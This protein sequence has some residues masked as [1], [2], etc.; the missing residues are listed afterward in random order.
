MKVIKQSVELMDMTEY[1]LH[2][3]ER[4]GRVCYKSEDQITVNSSEEF[5]RMLIK[6][7]HEAMIEHAH[8]SY[9]FVTDRGVTH[10]I[11][12]HR[13]FSY[14]QECVVGSTK[15]HQNYT[16]EDLYNRQ[17]SGN[18][19][20]K[21]H[22]KTI[23]LRSVNEDNEL[24]PN[25]INRILKK[26]VQDTVT[27]TTNLG[28]K[29]T[30]T[31]SHKF[32][33]A[34]GSYKR[35]EDLKVG[36]VVMTNGRV[37]M[38]PDVVE[39]MQAMYNEH[40]KTPLEI[41]NALGL[42]YRTVLGRLQ[43][44]GIF[45]RR[46]NDKDLGKY[47]KNHTAESYRK[48]AG[49]NKALYDSGERVVWNKGLKEGDHPGVGRQAESLRK[50]HHD[51]GIG[52]DNSCWAGGPTG[53]CEAQEM[54]RGITVCEICSST[55]FLEVHHKDKNPYNNEWPNIIKVCSKCHKMLDAG[56]WHYV[57]LARPDFI[58]S[59]EPAGEQMTYDLEMAAPNHNYVADGF[60]VHNST[61]Y[62]NYGNEV[63]FIEPVW[64]KKEWS[65]PDRTS[66]Q[67]NEDRWENHMMACENAYAKLLEK[68]WSAQE[69]RS[70]LPNSLKTEIVVTG[71]FREWRHFFKLR[72]AKVAH[73]QMRDLAIQ[74]L[75]SFRH[76]C[77]VIVED[78]EID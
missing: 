1:A 62:C 77:P 76:E 3:I 37:K 29:I 40:G 26:G 22:N 47:T 33:T 43:A 19:H 18:Q 48:S 10:E 71:N 66:E 58:L 12:R 16:I 46:K 64:F 42:S 72:T 60:V 70:V 49:T 36:D 61:R 41:A 75:D 69:A 23:N 25:K 53:H 52:M 51:N 34:D 78:I 55:R 65:H 20:D 67:S 35:L 27:V 73:P 63:T 28:Y 68:G 74:C 57:R 13:L 9:R 14:A 21:T 54:K 38:T 2:V 7:G 32:K 31:M 39:D 8:A 56:T 50:N 24:L 11:V 59:I 45:V 30:C 4:A 44:L 6:R 15:V 5:V 17:E